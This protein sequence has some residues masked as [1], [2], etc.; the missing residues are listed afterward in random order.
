MLTRSD[1]LI[2]G[3]KLPRTPWPMMP[4]KFSTMDDVGD[5][6]RR[7]AP[8]LCPSDRIATRGQYPRISYPC[9]SCGQPADILG[10]QCAGMMR[11]RGRPQRT[12]ITNASLPPLRSFNPFRQVIH[13]TGSP[14]DRIRSDSVSQLLTGIIA[15]TS[16]KSSNHEPYRQAPM[17]R[18]VSS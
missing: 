7:L 9:F 1:A 14:C 12:G 3:L 10:K 11:I 8:G 4:A 17:D 18:R 2:V 5:M 15:D 16:H 13:L 6:A